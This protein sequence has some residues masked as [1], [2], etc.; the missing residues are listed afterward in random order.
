MMKPVHS[1][2]HSALE[3]PL[4]PADASGFPRRMLEENHIP[5]FLPLC[6][7]GEALPETLSYDVTG[8]LSLTA[9]QPSKNFA[10]KIFAACYYIFFRRSPVSRSISCLRTVWSSMP[11]RFTWIRRAAPPAFST[12][13]D[14]M[15]TF[16]T[17]SPP[18]YMRSS[19]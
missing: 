13:R 6:P 5:G 3:L 14:N 7:T 11:T 8:L 15:R 16:R 1:A 4:S 2:T 12:T 19:R 10:P 18:F 9:P 17:V